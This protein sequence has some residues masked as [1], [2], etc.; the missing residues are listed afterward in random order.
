[1]RFRG[2]APNTEEMPVR[3]RSTARKGGRGVMAAYLLKWER[4][5]TGEHPV[6]TRTMRVRLPSLPPIFPGGAAEGDPPE[7]VKLVLLEI[8]GS[9]PHVVTI[10]LWCKSNMP[11]FESGVL[12]ANPGGATKSSTCGVVV[13]TGLCHSPGAGSIP[14]TWSIHLYFN[15]RMHG[16]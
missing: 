9:S 11:D 15:S 14:A 5:S 2:A 8:G 16:R 12:G 7:P 4:S 6:C 3:V 1:M 13:C 10:A